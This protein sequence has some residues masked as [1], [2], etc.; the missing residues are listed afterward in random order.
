MPFAF[1]VPAFLA[2]AALIAVPIIVHLIHREKSDALDFPSLMFVRQVP[3]R[4][5]QRRRI[6]NWP[7]LLLRCLALLLIIG[8]FARPFVERDLEAAASLDLAREIVIALDVSYSMEYGD[9]WERALA[10]ARESI[11]DVRPEDRATLVTFGVSARALTEP[12]SERARLLAL[13]AD[14]E[15][16][17]EATRFGPVLRLAQSIIASSDRPRAEVVLISDMQR[18]G[19]DAEAAVTLPAGTEFRPIAIVDEQMDNVAVTGVSQRREMFAGRERTIMTASLVNFG[20]SAVPARRVALLLDGRELESR[21]AS[22]EARGVATVEFAPVTLPSAGAR[23]T[24]RADA[25]AL[26][27]D[28]EFNIALSPGRNL[29]VLVVESGASEGA[30]LFLERALE[31][32]QAPRFQVERRAVG[33]LRAADLENRAVVILNDAPFPGGQ[34][35]RALLEYVRAGGGL[36]VATGERGGGGWSGEA[37]AILPGSIGRLVDRT[38]AGGGRIG[39]INAAHATVEEVGADGFAN[40][41]FYRYRPVENA[42]AE[43]VLARFDDGSVAIAEH[44]FGTGRVV[45]YASTL[46]TWWNDLPLQPV[47]LPFAHRLVRHA[48]EWGDARPWLQVGEVTSIASKTGSDQRNVMSPAGARVPLENNLLRVSETGFYEIRDVATPALVEYLA[49]NVD[50]SESEVAALTADEMTARVIAA[51]GAARAGFVDDVTAADWERR[52]AFWWYLL[53]L[54]LGMLVLESMLAGRF[55]RRPAVQ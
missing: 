3:H 29:N 8:A 43:G 49:V 48:A 2:A 21:T 34:A 27:I 7:L 6:R 31:I 15:P 51:D 1:L 14:L 33:Q 28:D 40:A 4:S 45:L 22:L 9:R 47:W 30:S 13:L 20:E 5:V 54:A 16:G 50:R 46:D 26:A 11:E 37:A 18:N 12:T 55:S 53:V 23:F 24:V 25:D 42:P 38:E 32:G 36:I 41:R 44:R 35:G 17:P 10:A 39:W 19:W 52:Q